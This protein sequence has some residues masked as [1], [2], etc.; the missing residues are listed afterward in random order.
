MVVLGLD[1]A[2]VPVDSRCE[3]LMVRGIDGE[4][5]RWGRGNKTS[6]GLGQTSIADCKD[7]VVGG[8]KINVRQIMMANFVPEIE[9][10]SIELFPSQILISIT[11]SLSFAVKTSD[12]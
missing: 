6:L 10:R 9:T 3:V 1:Q 8:G 4:V 7:K 11:F 12:S 5:C 2:E